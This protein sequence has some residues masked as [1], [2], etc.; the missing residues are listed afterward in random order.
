MSQPSTAQLFAGIARYAAQVNAN[1]SDSFP[2]RRNVA[3]DDVGESRFEAHDAITEVLT[4]DG[5]DVNAMTVDERD[6][7]SARID[8]IFD[9]FLTDLWHEVAAEVVADLLPDALGE[10]IADLN[11]DP[12]NPIG[13]VAFSDLHEIVDANEYL[14]PADEIGGNDLANELSSALDEIIVRTAKVYADDLLVDGLSAVL[15]SLLPKVEAAR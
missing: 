7:L 11:D 2:A 9:A 8:P 3:F 15:L 4:E 13:V 6:E 1:D 10:I 5:F 12:A 14:A